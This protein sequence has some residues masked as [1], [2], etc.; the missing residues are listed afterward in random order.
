M[1][2]AANSAAA[3]PPPMKIAVIGAGAAGLAATRILSRPS[4]NGNTVPS[5]VVLEKDERVG[6]IWDYRQEENSDTPKNDHKKKR[7]MYRGLR[8]NLPKEVMQ[9]REYPW[10]SKDASNDE[11]FMTHFKVAE[12]LRDYENE[13]GL[14]KHITFGATVKQL[15][16]FNDETSSASTPSSEQW[17][18]IQLEWETPQK[19]HSDCFDAVLVCNGHYAQPSSP[20]VSGLQEH[21]KGETIHSISYD[22]PQDFEGKTVLCIG[23]R[24]SGSDLAREISFHAKHVYLSD[25]TCSEATEVVSDGSNNDCNPVTWVP[26]TTAVNRD[27]SVEFANDC[28]LHPT[29]DC[30]IFCS[31]YDYSFPFI[32]EKSNLDLQNVPGE[33]RVTPLYKQLWHAQYPNLAFVGLPHSVV[34]FPMMEF[35]SEAAW[36]QWQDCTKLPSEG[37]RMEEA[38]KDAESGGA[39]KQGRVQDTHFLGDQQWNYCRDMARFAGLYDNKETA[40]TIEAYIA[41]N[42]ALYDYAGKARKTLL[43]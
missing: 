24:A 25:T 2:M 7:P 1:A 3:S 9:Y 21:Y 11:S 22:N 36:A 14:T 19:Q 32:N 34:P 43:P 13:F 40:E 8:T 10:K 23:G 27:G 35:Q 30:I 26:K 33:R 39:G 12:Y 5:I 18:K 29:P 31:G 37:E 42:K 20:H 17:P 4:G 15:T 16:M 6:G 28:P 38:Q 41:M